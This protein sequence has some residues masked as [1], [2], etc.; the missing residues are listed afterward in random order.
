[1][2]MRRWA[3]LYASLGEFTDHGGRRAKRSAR[4]GVIMRDTESGA[5]SVKLDL[6]PVLPGWSGW[7]RVQN[8][9]D[10]PGDGQP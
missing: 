2:T 7:L 1:M 9:H 5:M 8:V 6:V 3:D 10:E 4:V